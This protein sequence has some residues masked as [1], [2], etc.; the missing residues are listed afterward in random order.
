VHVVTDPTRPW[1]GEPAQPA[2]RRRERE[3]CVRLVEALASMW[4]V[5]SEA[6][7]TL[8]D[9]AAALAKLGDET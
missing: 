6:R 3:R 5:G 7:R 2:Q 1:F 9:A 4:P 8:R